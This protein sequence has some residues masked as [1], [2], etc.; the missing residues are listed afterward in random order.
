M[1]N[2]E[3]AFKMSSA[4]WRQI[5]LGLNMLRHG[6]NM[7]PASVLPA[8]DGPHVGPVNLAF[9]DILLYDIERCY[10]S[11]IRW[12]VT[13]VWSLKCMLL[14]PII[15]LSPLDTMATFCRTYFQLHFY[16]VMFFDQ[17]F[18]EVCSSGPNWQYPSNGLDNGL[19]QNRRQ[20]I[21]IPM[22]VSIVVI[23]SCRSNHDRAAITLCVWLV[24]LCRATMLVN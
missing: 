7:G 2:H 11:Y 12:R 20:V 17:N 18:I 3:N 21:T 13:M 24:L 22:P 4:K 16:E 6:A 14:Y 15:N 10:S 5:R 8:P 23:I 1:F 19:V 9:R